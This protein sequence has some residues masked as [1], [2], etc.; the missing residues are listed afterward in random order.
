MA[1][2]STGMSFS[3]IFATETKTLTEIDTN[4]KEWF[5]GEPPNITGGMAYLYQL[6]NIPVPQF[7][8]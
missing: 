2:I 7:M 8:Q 4:N 6:E 3:N 5:F 1:Y